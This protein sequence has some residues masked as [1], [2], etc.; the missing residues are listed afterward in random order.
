MS[1]ERCS[2]QK[3]QQ[4]QRH[5]ACHLAWSMHRVTGQEPR[6]A[7]FFPRPEHSLGREVQEVG[8]ELF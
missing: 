7:A 1:R 6:G 4:R 2:E 8:G 3:E 5:G